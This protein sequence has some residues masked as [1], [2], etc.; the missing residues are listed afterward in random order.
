MHSSPT[1]PNMAKFG[2]KTQPNF[3]WD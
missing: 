3:G 1:R 2:P